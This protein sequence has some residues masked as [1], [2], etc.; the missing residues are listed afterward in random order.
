M[1]FVSP[2]QRGTEMDVN[3]VDDPG[4]CDPS[5]VPAE[6]VPLRRVELGEGA[7]SLRGEVVDLDGLV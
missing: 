5:E 3:M 6:V 4:A 1:K 7:H 2:A